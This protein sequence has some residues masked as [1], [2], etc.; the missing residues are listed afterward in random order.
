[1]ASLPE[2]VVGETGDAPI[3]DVKVASLCD[4]ARR[5]A[6][7]SVE[8]RSGDGSPPKDEVTKYNPDLVFKAIQDFVKDLGTVWGK[9]KWYLPI[10][11]LISTSDKENKESIIKSFALSIPKEWKD[12]TQISITPSGKYLI[13]VGR[14]LKSDHK[15]KI[16]AH[17]KIISELL[18]G[19]VVLTETD[20]ADKVFD[21][22]KSTVESRMKGKSFKNPKDMMSSIMGD[23]DFFSSITES[24]QGITNKTGNPKKVL[25]SLHARLGKILDEDD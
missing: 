4:T 17:L 25:K 15:E 21:S 14:L 11:K 13:P 7:E 18:E 16:A 20:A 5:V 10:R 19:A 12:D 23:S 1:M 6:P 9:T 24:V 8:A 3:E 2:P 22:L